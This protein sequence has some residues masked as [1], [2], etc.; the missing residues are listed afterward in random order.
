M[1]LGDVFSVLFIASV[2]AESMRMWYEL[3]HGL[4]LGNATF[5]TVSSSRVPSDRRH[6]E[7]SGCYLR[8][9]IMENRLPWLYDEY[10]I[11][12][13]LYPF[14]FIWQQRTI[15]FNTITKS[16]LA[17]PIKNTR[18]VGDGVDSS[19]ITDANSTPLWFSC[20][21]ICMVQSWQQNHKTTSSLYIAIQYQPTQLA[22][23]NFT[24][25]CKQVDAYMYIYINIWYIQ[26][27][28]W[29]RAQYW[30]ICPSTNANQN[31]P[32]L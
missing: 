28:P 8:L 24:L 7:P 9:P 29:S 27:L 30:T 20:T 2:E 3:H 5:L 6:S 21:W 4:Q 19:W 17:P 31:K 25:P 23:A 13:V 26:Q 16:V 18:T 22:M 32:A 15:W 11:I 10:R 1:D 14:I 12:Y